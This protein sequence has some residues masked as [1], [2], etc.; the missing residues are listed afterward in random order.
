MPGIA[1]SGGEP[2]KN[3][4]PLDPGAER[5]RAIDE[6]AAIGA[7]KFTRIGPAKLILALP[8]AATAPKHDHRFSGEH[9]EVDRGRTAEEGQGSRGHR[10][11]GPDRR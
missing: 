6:D 5:R 7:R 11:A 1:A 8:L 2:M 3:P 9:V 10:A 4:L